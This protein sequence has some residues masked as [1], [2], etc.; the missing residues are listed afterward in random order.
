MDEFDGRVITNFFYKIKRNEPIEIYGNGKQTR[1]F[2][3]VS[4]MVRGLLAALDST[5]SGPINLGNPA[6][7][8]IVDFARKIATVAGVECRLE[9]R[10]LPED[11]P[12]Q[13]RPDIT[14]AKKLLG[15]EPQVSLDEGL[16]QTYRWFAEHSP[17]TK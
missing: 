6:E 3:Y 1:S 12:K 2:C 14:R 16:A 13:R 8:T 17:Q 7:M 5:E 9:Y 10:P 4:D 15:W 11:D